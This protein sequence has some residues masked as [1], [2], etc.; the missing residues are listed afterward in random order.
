LMAINLKSKLMQSIRR[1]CDFVSCLPELYQHGHI[2]PH[3]AT[4]IFWEGEV[5]IGSIE[6]VVEKDETSSTR[7]I[8]KH[9]G[10]S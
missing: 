10:S 5:I 4:I 3:H 6:E 9:V 1:L 2:N 7:W 8:G